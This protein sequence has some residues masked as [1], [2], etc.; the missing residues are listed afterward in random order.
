M[1]DDSRSRILNVALELFS[2]RGYHAVSVR[3]I[4]ER[5]GI[6]KTAVLYHFPSKRE[7]VVALV[8]PVLADSEAVLAA[9]DRLSATGDRRWAVIRGLLDVWLQHGRLLRMQMQDQ[10]LSADDATYLRLRDIALAA[11]SII[12]GPDADFGARVRAAQVYAALSDPVVIF[13][14]RDPEELRAAILGGAARLLDTT[15]P[16]ESPRPDPVPGA[17]AG[18][19]RRGRPGAMTPEMLESARRQRDSGRG[20]R[21]IAADIGVSRATLYRQLAAGD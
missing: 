9:A 5:V 2:A 6:T 15:P 4:A 19:R 20:M 14:G 11:Q 3:E 8:A 1:T 21:E 18:R 7:I 17:E 12:A 16:R 10:A 13:A